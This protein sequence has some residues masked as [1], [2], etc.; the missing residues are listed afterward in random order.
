MVT[1][2]S[3][4]WS[5]IND[6][7][8]SPEDV[9]SLAGGIEGDIK[10]TFRYEQ[11]GTVKVTTRTKVCK[12]KVRTSRLAADR[13]ARMLSSRAIDDDGSKLAC[14]AEEVF[15][16]LP[17]NVRKLEE[18]ENE[19]GVMHA[20]REVTQGIQLR[21]DNIKDL[22][23][24]IKRLDNEDPRLLMDFNQSGGLGDGGLETGGERIYGHRRAR[25]DEHTVRVTNLSET[26][27]DV[28]LR[29]LFEK[30]GQVTRVYLAKDK[31]TNNSKGFA[32]VTFSN[33]SHAEAAI[34]GLDRHGYDSLCMRVE[35]S[36]P[37]QQ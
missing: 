36:K 13:K 25:N 31:E 12:K 1:T 35:W 27:S 18:D 23:L 9:S 37:K 19:A 32:F 4:K 14:R 10:T 24:K 26:A 16:E 11:N 5:D 3:V 30:F 17:R 8:G 33:R 6:D 22:F 15:L 34:K 29:A 7:D 28:D 20:R 21:K 2:P